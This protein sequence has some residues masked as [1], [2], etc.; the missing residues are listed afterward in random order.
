MS[1]TEAP[2]ETVRTE[3]GK[4]LM[5]VLKKEYNNPDKFEELFTRIQNAE[6]IED[7]S[8]ILG[9]YLT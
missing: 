5:A 8:Y 6:T 9:D 1:V 4:S 2:R 3:K 7:W